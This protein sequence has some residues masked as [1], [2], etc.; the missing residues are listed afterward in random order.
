[1]SRMSHS[2]ATQATAR[3][4]FTRPHAAAAMAVLGLIMVGSSCS[5]AEDSSPAANTAEA[6][7]FDLLELEDIGGGRVNARIVLDQQPSAAAIEAAVPLII[8]MLQDVAPYSGATAFLY[9]RA[10]YANSVFTLGLIEDAPGG[11][12]AD[13]FGA[14]VGN[15][16]GHELDVVIY[17]RD[18]SQQPTPEEAAWYAAYDTASFALEER[19]VTDGDFD[20]EQ[21]GIAQQDALEQAAIEQAAEELGVSVEDVQAAVDAVISWQFSGTE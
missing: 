9:D 1:M 2:N 7:A 13:A 20:V 19:A 3:R 6:A 21:P 15:Y 11:R 14:P 10:E 4:L 16:D 17:E 12:W 8:V 5:S 18:W